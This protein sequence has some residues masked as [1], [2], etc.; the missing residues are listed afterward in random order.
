LCWNST[1]T[2]IGPTGGGGAAA[3]QLNYPLDLAFDSQNSL[4]ITDSRN[5]RVQKF[6]NGSSSGMTVAGS[7]NGTNGS[8]PTQFYNP[9]GIAIDTNDNI[10]IAD[11]YNNRVQMWNESSSY[12]TTVAGN[13][14]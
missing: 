12:G 4:Y 2:V 1:G 7:A 3:N 13:G 5:N 8:S 9:K 14:K 6:L 10:F 11:Y